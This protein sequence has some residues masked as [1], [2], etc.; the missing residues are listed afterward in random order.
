MIRGYCKVFGLL[1]VAVVLLAAGL[2]HTDELQPFVSDGCS[3]FPDGTPGQKDLWRSCCVDHDLAYWQGGTRR[4]RMAADK[5]LQECIAEVGVP[6][7]AALMKVGVWFGGS[8]YLP[9]PFRW[10]FGW[11]YLRGYRVLTSSEQL[12]VEKSLAAVFGAK[13]H[14][15]SSPD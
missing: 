9:F 6:K 4:Q 10:G 13:D 11:P 8:P 7:V 1:V 2:G 14:L 15:R 12:M 5:A 3:V